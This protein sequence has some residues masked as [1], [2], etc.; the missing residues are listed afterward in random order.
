MSKSDQDGPEG[1][2]A[3]RIGVTIRAQVRAGTDK[4]TIDVTDLSRTG[5][6]IETVHRLSL[7]SK[8]YLVIP[9]LSGFEAVVK[10]SRRDLYGCAFVTP[11]H[12]AV[13]AT[14]VKLSKTR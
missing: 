1:R 9:G 8:V 2:A 14:L 6:Q 7:D 4:M 12:E 5:F 11:L 10:W 13:F 3:E